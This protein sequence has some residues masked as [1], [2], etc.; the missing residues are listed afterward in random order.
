VQSAGCGFRLTAELMKEEFYRA[1]PVLHLT[2][3]MAG[4][5]CW[6]VR[7]S[8][9]APCECYAVVKKEYDR[10]LPDRLAA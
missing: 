3:R 7:G 2:T 10:L 4:F 8:S 6:I 9:G 1:G 5:R